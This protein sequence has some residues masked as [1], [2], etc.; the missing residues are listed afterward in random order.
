MPKIQASYGRWGC[1]VNPLFSRCHYR[2]LWM[3]VIYI[4]AW[5]EAISY[6][7]W[8]SWAWTHKVGEVGIAWLL[9]F[10]NH[11]HNCTQKGGI[12]GV[13][14]QLWIT[15]ATCIMDTP[16][17]LLDDMSIGDFQTSF[18][19]FWANTFSLVE[20]RTK[21]QLTIQ[22]PLLPQLV[23]LTIP[24]MLRKEDKIFT[25]LLWEVTTPLCVWVLL[26][27]LY[28]HAHPHVPPITSKSQPKH[29]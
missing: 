13:I 14:F 29:F 10:F 3:I 2:Q 18:G 16:L 23:P 27:Y 28:H 19:L 22:W 21:H 11:S 5:F 17:P 4:Y 25:N 20:M 6:V 1:Q 24:A 7:V 8:E 15:W 26:N 12:W 9:C